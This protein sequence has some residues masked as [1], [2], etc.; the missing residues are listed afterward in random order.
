MKHFNV[1]LAEG[2]NLVFLFLDCKAI[3]LCLDVSRCRKCASWHTV[4]KFTPQLTQNELAFGKII[5]KKGIVNWIIGSGKTHIAKIH[6]IP[7]KALAAALIWTVLQLQFFNGI[8]HLSF[9][10]IVFWYAAY[11]ANWND[12][13]LPTNWTLQCNFIFFG[14]NTQC[15]FRLQRERCSLRCT[16]P[17]RK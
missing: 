3:K 8:V 1:P 17:R 16:N 5:N 7:F 15:T 2:S 6:L 10:K 9:D 4:H 13:S 14:D 12:R 11:T